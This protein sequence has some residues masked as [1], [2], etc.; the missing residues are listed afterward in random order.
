MNSYC[1]PSVDLLS[2]ADV[3]NFIPSVFFSVLLYFRAFISDIVIAGLFGVAAV[4]VMDITSVVHV[5]LHFML[6]V[7]HC[8]LRT[9]VL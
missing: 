8:R 6:S 7:L 5:I 1:E 4:D 2:L 9:V 3:T